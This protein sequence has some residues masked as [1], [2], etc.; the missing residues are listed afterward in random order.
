M[1]R[2]PEGYRLD[3]LAATLDASDRA[4]VVPGNPGSSELVRRIRGVSRPRMPFDGPPWLAD[5]EMRLIEQWIA[6]G[7]RDSEGRGAPVPAGAR[8]RFRGAEEIRGVVQ[9]DGNI[10]VTRQRRR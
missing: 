2:P 6:Q 3:S 7:A 1:G 5:E 8:V 4:R 9:P 10:S